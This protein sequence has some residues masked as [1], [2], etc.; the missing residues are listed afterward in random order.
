MSI[1][2]PWIRFYPHDW[3]SDTYEMTPEQRGIYLP[4]LLRM[5]DKKAPLKDDFRMLSR[6]CNCSTRKFSGVVEYLITSGRLIKTDA[7]GLWSS[8]VEKEVKSFEDDLN[9]LKTKMGNFTSLNEQV[10]WR[11]GN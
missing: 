10:R 11:Y 8:E 1:K 4:L 2:L 5:H 3:I 9:S 7:G 6:F